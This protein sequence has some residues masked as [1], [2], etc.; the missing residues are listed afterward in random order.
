MAGDHPLVQK[1]Q[2][3][4]DKT[5]LI[6]P[7]ATVLVGYSGGADS[8][9]LLYAL[10][11]LG[12]PIV[13]GHLHH[14]MRPEADDELERCRSFC[15][16][17]GVRFE[18]GRADVPLLAKHGKMGL[19]EAGRLARYDFLNRVAL[20]LDLDLIAT[21]HTMDDHVETVILNLIRGSGLSGLA[22]IPAQRG[23]IVR[24]ML[25]ISRS[26]TRAFCEEMGLPFHDDPA[27]ADP[28]FARSRLRLTVIPELEKIQPALFETVSRL[29]AIA[30][31]E[32]A[33]LDR[34]AASA[35]EQSEA[36]S[37]PDLRF[38]TDSNELVFQTAVLSTYPSPL[39]RRCV[40]LAAKVVGGEL[41]YAQTAAAEAGIRARAS[42]ALTAAGGRVCVEWNP[43]SVAFR[44][45]LADLNETVAFNDAG[46][47]ASK[48]ANWVVELRPCPADN[49]M[50]PR[51]SLEAVFDRARVQGHLRCRTAKPGDAL[52]PLNM[53]GTKKV[54]DL[55]REAGLGINARKLLPLVCDDEGI[56]WIPG[57]CLADRV[58]VT[59]TTV[60]A[61]ELAFR[62][63]S[64]P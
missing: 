58:K 21:A 43:K 63:Q 22:G 53:A 62:A 48:A 18:A 17:L 59:P 44:Q 25:G 15:E 46:I 14:G 20:R 11:R 27:N 16:G 19:E 55:F 4:L 54:S 29:A 61:A 32:D 5:G 37:R 60:A 34:L 64:H 45:Q 6:P 28:A 10:Y 42:G 31:S 13:A 36:V 7:G 8:T 12:Y 35:L 47:A 49:Y 38:L 23:N 51:R 3:H 33:Y 9:F 40:R 30:A 2:N 57:V 52:R 26:E 41:D 50:R 24:P 56:I 39:L 1:L